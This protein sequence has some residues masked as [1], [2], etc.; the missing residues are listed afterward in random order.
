MST[1]KLLI[2]TPQ[3]K[4]GNGKHAIKL[5]NTKQLYR[6]NIDDLQP[7]LPESISMAMAMTNQETFT[8][9]VSEYRLNELNLFN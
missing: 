6:V 3:S 5:P 7:I 2:Y 4:R 1:I 9:S 8:L